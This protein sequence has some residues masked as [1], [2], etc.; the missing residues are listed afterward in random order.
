MLNRLLHSDFRWAFVALKLTLV[1]GLVFSGLILV[2]L[3]FSSMRGMLAAIPP[4]IQLACAALIMLAAV[5]IAVMLAERRRVLQACQHFL[6]AF[7]FVKP[8]TPAE[9]SHGLSSEKIHDIRRRG[10]ALRGKPREWWLGLEESLE[11]YTNIDGTQGWFLTRPVAESLPD[12]AIISPFY[13]ASFH[14]AVPSILTALGLLATF[15]AILSAL[16]GVSYN[17]QDALRPVTGIDQLIN[18]LSGKFLSSIIALIL[19]VIFIIVEKK[20]GERHILDEYNH[21]VHRCQEIFPFLSQS[22]ILLDLQR[23]AVNRLSLTEAEFDSR[24]LKADKP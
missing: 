5:L 16:S 6:A 4:G 8:S 7:E 23:L 10:N 24:F 11:C 14:Q 12:D 1:W 3:L 13:H 21:L 19:S 20:I 18:G 9:K 2:F 15:V 17:V 22:R